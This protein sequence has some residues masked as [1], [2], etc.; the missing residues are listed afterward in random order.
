MDRGGLF[1][2]VGRQGGGPETGVGERDVFVSLG[3]FGRVGG[4]EEGLGWVR[5]RKDSPRTSRRRI[6]GMSRTDR[7]GD[8]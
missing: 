2:R 4:V 8:H 5:V 7:S 1:A 6:R 3:R